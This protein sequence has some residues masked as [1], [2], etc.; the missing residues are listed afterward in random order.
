MTAAWRQPDYTDCRVPTPG[1]LLDRLTLLSHFSSVSPGEVIKATFQLSQML[2]PPSADGKASSADE[3]SA[4]VELLEMLAALPDKFTECR[5]V[6]MDDFANSFLQATDNIL[7]P[8]NI[9][10][11]KENQEV[12]ADTVR[13][14]DAVE[15]FTAQTATE[16]CELSLA[17]QEDTAAFFEG[18]YDNIVFRKSRETARSFGGL[19]YTASSPRASITLPPEVFQGVTDEQV[20]LLVVLYPTIGDLLDSVPSTIKPSSGSTLKVMSAIVTS[21]GVH[22]SGQAFQKLSVPLCINFTKKVPT[23]GKEESCVYLSRTESGE[24]QWLTDGC[25]INEQRNGS[26]HCC[27][28]HMTSFALLSAVETIEPY[29]LLLLTYVLCSASC[30]IIFLSTLILFSVR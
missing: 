30:F 23:F 12:A 16:T 17:L 29:H 8:S 1:E 22:Q 15:S 21:S 10:I 11:W 7:H 4:F 13:I 25:W 18:K 6:D 24:S 2:A 3:Y 28:N 14:M 5:Q 9:D 19:S 20:T 26:V 27:C